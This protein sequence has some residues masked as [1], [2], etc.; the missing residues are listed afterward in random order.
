MQ[1][2]VCVVKFSTQLKEKRVKS[3]LSANQQVV[4][5]KYLND[6]TTAKTVTDGM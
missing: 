5:V 1:V 2:R 6:I 3:S 4:E